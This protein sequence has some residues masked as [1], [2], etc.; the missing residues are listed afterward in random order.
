MSTFGIH[1]M[2]ELLQP[3][4]NV[5]PTKCSRACLSAAARLCRG[6]ACG[7]LKAVP[8]KLRFFDRTQQR[9][10]ACAFQDWAATCLTMV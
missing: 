4:R 2:Q 5:Y 8:G 1:L 6:L 9:L 7:R 10:S 3:V